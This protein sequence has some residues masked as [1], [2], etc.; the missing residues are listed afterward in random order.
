MNNFSSNISLNTNK[1]YMIYGRL[2]IYFVICSAYLLRIE[3]LKSWLPRYVF[4]QE[5]FLCNFIHLQSSMSTILFM[6]V[7]QKGKWFN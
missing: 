3:E 2:Q 7:S 6:E 4:V 1:E 5:S